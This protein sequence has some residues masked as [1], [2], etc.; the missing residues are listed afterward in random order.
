M[1][2]DLVE[3]RHTHVRDSIYHCTT[4][5]VSLLQ[6]NIMFSSLPMARRCR[7]PERWVLE[8][9]KLYDDV[10]HNRSMTKI[11]SQRRKCQPNT[12]N[13]RKGCGRSISGSRNAIRPI[14]VS[15]QRLQLEVIASN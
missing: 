12:D 8:A 6:K 5:Y 14:K 11:N 2:H 15:S 3:I 7:R 10:M 1:D 4:H 13:L 9:C